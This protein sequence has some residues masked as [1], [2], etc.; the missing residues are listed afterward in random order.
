MFKLRKFF[1]II[2]AIVLLVATML[3]AATYRHVTVNQLIDHGERSNTAL[4]GALANSIWPQ[5][6]THL[7]S[8]SGLTGDELRAHPKTEQLHR[9]VLAQ[10]RGLSV[11]KIKIYDITGL[12]VFSTEASQIGDDKS[13]NPGFLSA[14]SGEIASELTHR[15]TFSAF[16]QVIEDRDVLASYVPIRGADGK[17]QGVFE[18]YG[19][20]T[21]LLRKINRVQFT[22]IVSSI[23][24]F[25]ALYLIL[26][27]VVFH[28]DKILK[29]QHKDLFESQ[30]E[31]AKI[32]GELALQMKI[33]A[34]AEN[35]LRR[36]NGELE[37]LV[38]RRTVELQSKNSTLQEEVRRRA[39]AEYEFIR[40]KDE[41][42]QANQAKSKFLA[43]MSHELRT[44][45]NAII[46]YTELMQEESEDRED[47]ALKEDLTKVRNAGKHLLGLVNDVLDLSKVE[48]GKMEL[49]LQEA[50]LAELL[51][52]IDDT[53]QPLFAEN[54]NTFEIINTTTVNSFVTDSQKLRQALLNLLGNAAKF[55]TDGHVR[56]EVNEAPPGW[57]NFIISDTGVGISAEQLNRILEP[58]TQGDTGISLKYGGTGLGLSI[59][60][61][62]SELLG[63]E[64]DMKSEP[65]KGSRFT[66]RL[67]IRQVYKPDVPIIAA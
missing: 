36:F 30:Q 61:S 6:S 42:E 41:A 1:S 55:T 10:L 63:G 20:V 59:T 33:R 2:S 52:N 35:E 65:G 26:Y 56:L 22:I 12:T 37:E 57:L 44:P 5:F 60:K 4:A 25:G 18:L 9:I 62:F 31:L 45:L 43:N 14:N 16:E 48:F 39:S 17:I 13:K 47:L 34:K 50:I 27:L 49:H 51:A 3:L 66:I 28:A 29:R 24:I 32:N 40:A 19:D 8:M 7:T 58:F 64:L 15:D 46:G 38:R 11:V 21:P 54:G 23:A 53:A 67:P